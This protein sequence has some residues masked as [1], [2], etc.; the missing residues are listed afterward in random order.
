MGHTE[1][2]WTS[3]GVGGRTHGVVAFTNIGYAVVVELTPKGLGWARRV[4]LAE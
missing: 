4:V 1:T 2:S 3:D